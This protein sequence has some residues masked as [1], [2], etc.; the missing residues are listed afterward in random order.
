MVEHNLRYIYWRPVRIAYGPASFLALTRKNPES[1]VDAD[2]L[3]W[4]QT[5][6]KNIHRFREK[7]KDFK[8]ITRLDTETEIMYYENGGIL[9]YVLNTL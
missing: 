9:Q 5:D 4:I 8:V 1:L 6:L 2:I 7:I 3:E